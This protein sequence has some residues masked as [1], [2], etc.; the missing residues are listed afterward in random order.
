MR[1][2]NYMRGRRIQKLEKKKSRVEERLNAVR[3][4]DESSAV[5]DEARAMFEKPDAEV[6]KKLQKARLDRHLDDLNDIEKLVLLDK[7]IK[8]LKAKQQK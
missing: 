1:I 4:L 7:R 8:E 3:A 6:S 5:L 2:R